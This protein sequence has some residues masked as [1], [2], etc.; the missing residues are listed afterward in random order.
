MLS[1][2]AGI[3]PSIPTA[4]SKPDPKKSGKPGD[5]SD[6]IAAGASS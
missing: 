2:L 1:G 4:N 5:D 6:R 3:V